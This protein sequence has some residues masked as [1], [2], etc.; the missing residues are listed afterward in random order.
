MHCE[1]LISA[2][3]LSISEYH[4]GISE[5]KKKQQQPCV[6]LFKIQYVPI[7]QAKLISHL[8]SR[9]LPHVQLHAA[10]T[11]PFLEHIEKT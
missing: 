4:Q 2:P 8:L 5:G 3:F 7:S 9:S 1:L 10:L 6:S 11:K